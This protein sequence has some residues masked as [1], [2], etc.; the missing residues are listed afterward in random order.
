MNFCLLKKFIIIDSFII[1]R[2]WSFRVSEKQTKNLITGMCRPELDTLTFED[3]Q[4]FYNKLSTMPLH[5]I[6]DFVESIKN[7]NEVSIDE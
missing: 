4:L 7:N 2:K 6:A 5:R 3:M 1:N